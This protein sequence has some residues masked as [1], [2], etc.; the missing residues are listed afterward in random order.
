MSQQADVALDRLL[1]EYD[2]GWMIDQH[3]PKDQAIPS[4]LKLLGEVRDEYQRRVQVDGPFTPDALAAEAKGNPHRVRA[5]LQ[6]L[7]ASRSPDMLVMVWRVLQGL[8]IR[9]LD[10]S[11][12]ELTAFRLVVVLARPGEDQDG[13]ESYSSGDIKDA[14][15]VRHFGISTIEGRPLFDSYYPLRKK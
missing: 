14:A 13:L 9:Q 5:F 10:M 7:A 3:T 11:Y 12:H 4:L 6:S 8:R 15:L 1:R 2:L